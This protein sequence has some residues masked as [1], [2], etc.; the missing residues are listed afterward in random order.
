MYVFFILTGNFMHTSI[1]LFFAFLIIAFSASS[2][3]TLITSTGT[4]VQFTYDD[5][6]LGLFGTPTVSGNSLIF[7]PSNFT[8]L[9]DGYIGGALT[10]SS[11]EVKIDALDGHHLGALALNETGTYIREGV[12]AGV[13]ETGVL[14]AVS[15]DNASS[16]YV[17]N[18]QPTA[19]FSET[20][21]DS[22]S[23]IW[24][25]KANFDLLPGTSS[26]LVNIDNILRAKIFSGADGSETAY[27][28]QN[29]ASLSVTAVPLPMAAWLFG[30]GLLMM[31]SKCK[32]LTLA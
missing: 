4:N 12:N 29:F 24:T 22:P 18:I 7:A 5:M 9:Q 15:L 14:N 6:L 28:G 25:A 32:R 3:A 31:F 23:S 10:E 13:S 20:A 2:H 30:G 1:K 11:F 19:P 16:T 26:L 17:S 21:F 27:I 8:A